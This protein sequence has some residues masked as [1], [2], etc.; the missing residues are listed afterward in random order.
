MGDMVAI[1]ARGREAAS[2]L[3]RVIDDDVSGCESLEWRWRVEQMQVSTNLTSK[4]GEDVAASIFLLFGD[5]YKVLGP[6]REPIPAIRYVW[7]GGPEDVGSI[8]DNLYLPGMVKSIIL[9]GRD[10]ETKTWVTERRN[11][12]KDYEAAFGKPSSEPIQGL[13]LFIDNDQTREDVEA[14]YA[15]ARMGC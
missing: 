6:D 5:P 12:F 7:S 13:I 3:L 1:R 10:A 14:Y 15:W 2:G 8:I 9:R 11:H 4:D